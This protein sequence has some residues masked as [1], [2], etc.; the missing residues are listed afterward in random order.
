MKLMVTARWRSP[1]RSCVKSI[2]ILFP[3]RM[4]LKKN[5][6]PFWYALTDYIMGACAWMIF[7]FY[8]KSILGE[9]FYTDQKFLL[10]VLFIPAGWL[11]LYGLVGSY[12][13]VYKKSRL[14]EFTKT[15]VC[16]IIG[17]IVL[18]F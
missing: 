5:I 15:F 2:K 16:S 8:R 18:F 17:C 6:H 12:N 4:S 1:T 10:G 9:G 11:I 3:D 14:T 13:S 7:Y